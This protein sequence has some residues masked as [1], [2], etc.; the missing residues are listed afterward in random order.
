MCTLSDAVSLVQQPSSKRLIF[1]MY[2]L[3]QDRASI[4]DASNSWSYQYCRFLYFNGWRILLRDLDSSK[5]LRSLDLLFNPRRD[6]RGNFLDNNW[7]G[8][9]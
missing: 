9:C 3:L 2:L 5:E 1:L 4:A 6:L 7:S 8:R